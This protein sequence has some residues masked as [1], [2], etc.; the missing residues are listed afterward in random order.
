M[1]NVSR[2]SWV[3]NVV[4]C[5]LLPAAGLTANAQATPQSG[6]DRQLSRLDI[7]VVASAIINKDSNGTVV[8]NTVPTAVNL[9]PGNTV[10]PLVTIRYTKSPYLGFEFNYAYA[11]Y[12]QT[13][14]PFGAAPVGG[15]QQNASEY[16][17]GYVAHFRREFHGIAPFAGGGAG[18]TAF[19][20]T[21]GG[22]EGLSPQA[23]ATYYYNVGGDYMLNKHFGAR[24]E[25]RQLF[26]KAPD[27][28]TN[29]LTIQKHTTE[30][31]PGFGFFFRF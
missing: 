13:F 21:P 25:F 29:Y 14:T 20:P 28:E 6:L 2:P 9:H 8:I 30:L 4:L 24:A 11:R 1:L 3:R 16:T 31:Q 5:L 15:V 10:G 12:T 7:G 26:F 18:T 23:R 27:F 19:R 22:G 17:F